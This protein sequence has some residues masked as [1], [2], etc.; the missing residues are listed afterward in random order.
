MH[1]RANIASLSPKGEAFPRSSRV[2]ARRDFRA[3]YENGVKHHGRLVAVFAKPRA[4][5]G[6]RLGLTATRK[7]GGAVVRNRA[8]RRVREIFRRWAAT[9][10]HVDVDLVVNISERATRSPFAALSSEVTALFSRAAADARK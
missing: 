1:A 4:E 10:A 2:R 8:R 6:L 9:A 5:G 7:A 3:A